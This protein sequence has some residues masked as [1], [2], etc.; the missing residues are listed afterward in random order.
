MFISDFKFYFEQK[1]VYEENLMKCSKVTSIVINYETLK[2]NIMGRC[3]YLEV[4]TSFTW[5][6]H[7]IQ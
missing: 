3:Y 6:V 2:F 1:V 7:Q 4:N 5:Q